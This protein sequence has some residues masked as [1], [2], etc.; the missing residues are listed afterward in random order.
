MRKYTGEQP[1]NKQEVAGYMKKIISLFLV[2]MVIAAGAAATYGSEG[3]LEASAGEDAVSGQ[4][5]IINSEDLENTMNLFGNILGTIITAAIEEESIPM[6]T[7]E[8]AVEKLA[9]EFPQS[10]EGLEG[11][12]ALVEGI[13]GIKLEDLGEEGINALIENILKEYSK[14]K[15]KDFTEDAADGIKDLA[16]NAGGFLDGL[17]DGLIGFLGGLSEGIAGVLEDVG[18]GVSDILNSISANASFNSLFDNA[19][20][21]GEIG[22]GADNIAGSDALNVSAGSNA[23]NASAGNDSIVISAGSD[24]LNASAGNDA[25]EASAGNDTIVIS[26]GN[27]LFN[28]NAGNDALDASAGNDTIIISAGIDNLISANTDEPKPLI[29]FEASNLLAETPEF[30]EDSDLLQ[31]LRDDSGSSVKVVGGWKVNDYANAYMADDELAVFEDATGALIGVDYTPITLLA[32]QLVAG[33]NY[34]FLCTGTPV[35]LNAKPGWYIIAVYKDLQ[36]I[37]SI[38]SIEEIVLDDIKTMDDA[39]GQMMVGAWTLQVPTGKPYMLA[40]D[41]QAAFE[42]ACKAAGYDKLQ[43][44]A[45]LGTQLVAGTNYKVLCAGTISGDADNLYVADIYNDLQ[46]DST[47]TDIQV[48]DLAEYISYGE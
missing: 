21:I 17:K 43:P 13:D 34:A 35:T 36:G 39:D 37:S 12:L 11:L 30:A 24:A 40:E 4:G 2:V 45:L 25:L 33:N 41:A 48:F 46:G 42:G 26:A 31:D 3:S 6:E 19:T 5:N 7:L 18:E 14:G 22:I 44:V 47:F 23:I 32:T 20:D 16:D 8:D 29:A 28:I 1:V 27:E 15:A 38:M 9:E 10:E